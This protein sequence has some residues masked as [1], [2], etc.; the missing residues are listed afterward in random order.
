M[1][2]TWRMQ[3][4]ASPLPP[5]RVR[6]SSRARRVRLV[7]APGQG[8]TV[9]T[10]EGFDPAL[11]P[12]IVAGRLDWVERHLR[13][14]AQAAPVRDAAPPPSV[15]ELR[16]VGRS[17]NVRYRAGD[18]AVAV[19]RAGPSS[20]LV[21]GTIAR[22]DMVCKGL[23]NWLRREASRELESRLH[24]LSAETGLAFSGA[25]VR[26]QRTR[27]GSCSSR[28]LI[29][30]N[31]RL[32]FLPSGLADYVLLHELAHTIHLNHSPDYWR[33]LEDVL[34]GARGF[35]RELRSARRFVPDWAVD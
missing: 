33:F 7:I 15:V 18:G 31:A 10:P 24:V 20:L 30:L 11:V 17:V 9:V 5:F 4:E 12:G 29:S 25:C 27:W 26:M 3:S 1:A 32:L 8:L 21:S 13:R 35:D 19:R 28:G 14:V 2:H 16:A 23:R 22:R 34:P 6:A